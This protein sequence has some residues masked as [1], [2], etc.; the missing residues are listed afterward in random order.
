RR[1]DGGRRPRTGH[2]A[3]RGARWRS[4]AVSERVAGLRIARLEA[5][6]E[7]LHALRRRAVRERLRLDVTLR[8]LLDAIVAD[9]GRRVGTRRAGALLEDLTLVRGVPP[10]AGKAVGL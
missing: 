4:R 3:W 6:L 1:R 2:I 10:H 9:G 8:L 5:P 7:P